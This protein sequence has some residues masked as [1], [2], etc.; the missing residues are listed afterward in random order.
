KRKL[1]YG[2]TS[3]YNCTKLVWFEQFSDVNLAIA[4]EKQLKTWERSW[5]NNLIE[6]LNPE[7]NDL[8]AN[9]FLK[10]NM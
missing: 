1:V 2:F 4:R 9:W 3:K 7:W 5:K 6:K 8:A 10:G